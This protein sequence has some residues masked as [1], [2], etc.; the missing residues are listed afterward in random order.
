M[1]S[2]TQNEQSLPVR[3]AK[4]FAQT[5]PCDSEASAEG[6][7]W[8]WPGRCLLN[9]GILHTM[10]LPAWCSLLVLCGVGASCV[11]PHCWSFH[12]PPGI[13]ISSL[14][15]STV[16]RWE[17]P[18]GSSPF[19][20]SNFP[21]L[22]ILPVHLPLS[23]PSVAPPSAQVDFNTLRV[24]A[25][26]L[27]TEVICLSKLVSLAQIG[28]LCPIWLGRVS[29]NASQSQLLFSH[30]AAWKPT[31][32][33]ASRLRIFSPLQYVQR[34]L[35]GPSNSILRKSGSLYLTTNLPVWTKLIWQLTVL[36]NRDTLWQEGVS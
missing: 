34:V 28:P 24:E 7:A 27:P 19:P 25:S 9:W 1:V 23:A 12:C 11:L 30:L 6:L 20:I 33:C 13:R 14:S 15:L 8:R 32:T 22:C 36:W 4:T 17:L 29:S 5:N 10:D 2:R 31:L 21:W 18:L 3:H 26:L 35:R 16:S